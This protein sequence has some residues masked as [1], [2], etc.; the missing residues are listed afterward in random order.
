MNLKVSCSPHLRSPVNTPWVMMQVIVALL[1]ATIAAIILFKQRAAFLIANCVITA[2]VT[3]EI[4]QKIRKKPSTVADYS[5]VLTG[6]LL[7]LILPPSTRW[8]AASLGSIFAIAVGKHL[9]G[10]LGA[11]IFNP[12]LIGR[13]FLMAAY[14]K[15]LTTFIAPSS[16]D[17]I[18]KATPLALR[19]FSG[20]ITPTKD[21]FLGTI[22]GSLGETSAV[23]LIIGGAYLLWRKIADWRIPLTVLTTTT[24]ISAIFH[25][26]NPL[27]GS[28]LFHLF[29]GGL[30]LGA[31]FMATDPVTTPTTK[32]GRYIFGG[33][34]AILIMI[35]RYFSGLPEGVM[36]S[37][38]FMNALTPLINSYTQ[39]KRF[40][41]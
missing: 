24:V 1:P 25:I 32:T 28:I 40:G 37:I 12:A 5:G 17:A 19:K 4:I 41:E 16:V 10:G 23:C 26:V 30:L 11:N 31:F 9:F 14:P 21:L 8:Y 7:A 13:A 18:T 29:S 22:A 27:N 35:I 3:E 20:V 34:C 33:G 6:L 2:L 39:P 38:L 15:M 36:Y